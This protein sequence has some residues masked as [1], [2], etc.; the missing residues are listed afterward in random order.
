MKSTLSPSIWLARIRYWSSHRR[1]TLKGA[2]GGSDLDAS[3]TRS[4]QSR[5]RVL[6]GSGLDEVAAAAQAGEEAMEALLRNGPHAVALALKKDAP[7]MLAEYRGLNA[8]FEKRL[9]RR[10]GPA[11]DLFFA[12]T[13]CCQ[14][15]GSDGYVRASA[16]SISDHERALL[17]AVSG[18]QARTCRQAFEVH[19]LLAAGFPLGARALARAM[20]EAAVVA[21]VLAV[22][23]QTSDHEELGLRFLAFDD[24]ANFKDAEEYQRH[25]GRLG[26][27][28]FPDEEMAE[29]RAAKRAALD[30]FPDL[31]RRFG[32]AG[33]LPGLRQRTFQELEAMAQLDHLRPYYTWASHEI[34]A[35][36]KGVR[37]NQVER[38]DG[39]VKLTGRTNEGLAD[40]AQGAL[41]S[42]CQVTSSMLTLP[43]ITSPSAVVG[44]HA[45]MELLDEACEELARVERELKSE[46]H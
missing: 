6:V 46:Q 1:R 19:T 5:V 27:E 22:F 13:V 12:I 26:H 15:I 31:D 30:L 25:A 43:G 39:L 37:L 32:W 42:L 21:D 41:I 3:F 45:A 4:M 29:L 17:E 16:A 38:P 8:A 44:M 36:P 2:L 10:W 18:L 9:Y 23:G 14:E 28:P 11:L 24:V 35:T 33:D 7:R 40:P 34:H 20:H